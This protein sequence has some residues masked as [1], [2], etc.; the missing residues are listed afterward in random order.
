[1]EQTGQGG[2]VHLSHHTKDLLVAAGKSSWLTARPTKV[3][4]KGK[5]AMETYFLH[6]RSDANSSVSDT[7]GNCDDSDVESDERS[8]APTATTCS[9]PASEDSSPQKATLTYTTKITSA[10]KERLVQWNCDILRRLL[11]QIVARRQYL[12]DANPGRKADADERVYVGRQVSLV[13]EV[14]ESISM[15]SFDYSTLVAEQANS[16]ELDPKI[17]EQLVDFV[18]KVAAM[19]TDNP[20]HSCT[21]NVNDW[22]SCPLACYYRY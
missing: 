3:I 16:I 17:D 1:M 18:R 20:F 22:T 4:A 15:P 21:S 19:Y 5:G 12:I 8:A 11:K 14:K 10:K 2:Q 13:H 9:S 7:S 6:I